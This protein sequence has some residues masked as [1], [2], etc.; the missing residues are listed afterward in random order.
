M[1]DLITKIKH[2]FNF[3]DLWESEALLQDLSYVL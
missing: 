1:L 2:L 3:S